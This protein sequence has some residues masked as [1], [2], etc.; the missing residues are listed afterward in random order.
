MKGWGREPGVEVVRVVV[1]RQALRV[2]VVR[3]A[4]FGGTVVVRQV[5]KAV[6]CKVSSWVT[7]S[8][9]YDCEVDFEGCSCVYK[10]DG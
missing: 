9:S 6:V 8:V 3:K 5:L 2:V 4:R 7:V 10:S 1:M